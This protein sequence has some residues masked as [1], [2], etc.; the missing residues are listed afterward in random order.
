[1]KNPDSSNL[2]TT[3]LWKR[4]RIALLNGVVF[5]L[6]VIFCSRCSRGYFCSAEAAVVRQNRRPSRSQPHKFTPYVFRIHRAFRQCRLLPF[7]LLLLLFF[8]AAT[9]AVPCDM[10]PAFVVRIHYHVRRQN[11]NE[12]RKKLECF[13]FYRMHYLRAYS[14]LYCRRGAHL[15]FCCALFVWFY[16]YLCIY[17]I[18]STALEVLEHYRGNRFKMIHFPFPASAF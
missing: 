14:A 10:T 5:H 2:F 7:V 18:D 13:G 4:L 12:K 6:I 15:L 8:C 1:M 11:N 9:S 3:N 17:F 16:F